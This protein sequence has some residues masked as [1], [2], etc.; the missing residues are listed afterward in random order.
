[1]VSL[2]VTDS[3]DVESSADTVTITVIPGFKA[4]VADAGPDQDNIVPGATVTGWQRFLG[5]PTQNHQV[6]A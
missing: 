2:R 6:M 1:M 3:A 4:P 5:G